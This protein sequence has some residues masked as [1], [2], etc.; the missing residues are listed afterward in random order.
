MQSP[1]FGRWCML[2]ALAHTAHPSLEGGRPTSEQKD[3]PLP[4]LRARS[5]APD[6]FE[7]SLWCYDLFPE[8]IALGANPKLLFVSE[9][10]HKSVSPS[11]PAGAA[12]S[13]DATLP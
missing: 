13:E 6:S 5:Q 7:G 3:A 4:R 12:A 9:R 1:S 8:R 11:G 10:K 2:S